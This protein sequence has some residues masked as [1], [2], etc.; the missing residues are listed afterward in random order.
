MPSTATMPRLPTAWLASSTSWP[1]PSKSFAGKHLLVRK[2][3]TKEQYH[4]VQALGNTAEENDA[5]AK[6]DKKEGRVPETFE[7]A[8]SAPIPCRGSY[9]TIRPE[10]KK[11]KQPTVE[12][13][14]L[15]VLGISR[16]SRNHHYS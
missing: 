2:L 1:C 14:A 12:G 13:I 6:K 4:Q 16:R 5:E 8:M 7:I 3:I 9:L 10:V 11:T 15:H